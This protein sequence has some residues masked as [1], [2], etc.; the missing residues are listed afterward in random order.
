MKTREQWANEI[1]AGWRRSV[2]DIIANGQQLI[3][4]KEG[5]AGPAARHV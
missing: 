1:T 2:E 4:A 5:P 3:D